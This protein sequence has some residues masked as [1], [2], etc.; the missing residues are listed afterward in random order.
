MKFLKDFLIN[1]AI[2]VAGLLIIYW[3][4]HDLLNIGFEFFKAFIGAGRSLL[5]LFLFIA[6]AALPR[7]GWRR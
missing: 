2:I 3:I 6:L 1:F 4:S 7:R 5:F